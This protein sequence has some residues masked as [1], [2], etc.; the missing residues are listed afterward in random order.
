[1]YMDRLPK[2]GDELLLF[3]GYYCFELNSIITFLCAVALT[4]RKQ[5]MCFLYTVVVLIEHC[6][7]YVHEAALYVHGCHF[8]NGDMLKLIGSISR[9]YMY[10]HCTIALHACSICLKRRCSY[11]R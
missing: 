1:M 8:F 3:I 4:K 7:F 11:V 9:V 10:I 2:T 6:S 5:C